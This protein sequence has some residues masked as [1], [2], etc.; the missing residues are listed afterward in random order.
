VKRP[1]RMRE[2]AVHGIAVVLG[3]AIAVALVGSTD[4]GLLWRTAAM[5][6]SLTLVAAGL[7]GA[8]R[9]ARSEWRRERPGA[10]AYLGVLLRFAAAYLLVVVATT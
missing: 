7:L 6:L 5:S 3:P 1:R 9:L 4:T 8:S 10:R 2:R